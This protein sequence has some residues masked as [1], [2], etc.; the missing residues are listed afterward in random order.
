MDIIVRDKLLIHGQAPANAYHILSK[1]HK[2][3]AIYT[4]DDTTL[5][6]ESI[7]LSRKKQPLLICKDPK[8]SNYTVFSSLDRDTVLLKDIIAYS[9]SDNK[10]CIYTSNNKETFEFSYTG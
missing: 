5:V 6:P 4:F 10:Q 1:K 9:I 7:F 2:P 8:T 3:N